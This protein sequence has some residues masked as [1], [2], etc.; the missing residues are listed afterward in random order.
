MPCYHSAMQG[1]VTIL[2]HVECLGA[3]VSFWAPCR[4]TWQSAAEGSASDQ[5]AGF[6]LGYQYRGGGSELCSWRWDLNARDCMDAVVE[7]LMW[8]LQPKFAYKIAMAAGQIGKKVKGGKKGFTLE[9]SEAEDLPPPL[10]NPK[11]PKQ[12][13]PK[14][15]LLMVVPSC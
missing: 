8:L 13:R 7:Q 9:G 2:C 11:V 6:Q 4:G 3:W 1:L 5:D 10:P 14:I 15:R 12:I